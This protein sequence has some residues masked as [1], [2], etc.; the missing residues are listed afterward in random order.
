MRYRLR[1][2]Y[3]DPTHTLWN[4][5]KHLSTNIWTMLLIVLLFSFI[6]EILFR[7][8]DSYYNIGWTVIT[9]VLGQSYDFKRVTCL[10]RG[11]LVSQKLVSQKLCFPKTRFTKVVFH[12]T[13]FTKVAFH[14]SCVSQKLRF[15]KVV[16]HKNS[17]HKSCVSQKLR[18]TKVAFHKNSF[19]KK[20]VSQK[21]SFG[22]QR[23]ARLRRTVGGGFLNSFDDRKGFG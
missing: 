12:K 10:W 14:K 5:S 7:Q 23:L 9:I 21:E 11:C 19:H 20:L 16:F 22:R 18:F 17:F 15:T 3:L 6:V 4:C 8:S 1:H 13:R 2:Q